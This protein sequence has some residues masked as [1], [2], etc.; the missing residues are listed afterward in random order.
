VKTLYPEYEGVLP[1]NDIIEKAKELNG[2]NVKDFPLK[3]ALEKGC[4]G[5]LYVQTKSYTSLGH[6]IGNAPS[7]IFFRC[8]KIYICT[9]I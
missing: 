9:V 3:S 2:E 5:E 7:P 4:G 1:A 6:F 8:S